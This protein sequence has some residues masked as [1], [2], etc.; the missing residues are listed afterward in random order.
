MTTV[1]DYAHNVN[2]PD[3]AHAGIGALR[4]AGI[5]AV[6]GIGLTLAPV[7]DPSFKGAEAR[8]RL[9]HQLADE[10][11]GSPDALVRLGVAPGEAFVVG[12]DEMVNQ[13]RTAARSARRSPTTRNALQ[14]RNV[15]GDVEVLAEHGLLG[16]DLILVHSQVTTPAEWEQIARTGTWVSVET[17]SRWGWRSGPR[18]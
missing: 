13:F 15:P 3:D 18:C 17:R 16:D 10:Y 11:F 14:V 2:T 7:E 5:R 1:T 6:Y 9:V 8:T 12:L 4:D